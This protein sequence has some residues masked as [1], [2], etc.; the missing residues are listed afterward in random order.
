MIDTV[1]L[2]GGDDLSDWDHAP[3]QGPQ[4]PQAAAT[5][6]QWI[7]EQLRASTYVFDNKYDLQFSR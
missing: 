3:L 7:E 2:C 1:L 5:Y 6:W 4:N